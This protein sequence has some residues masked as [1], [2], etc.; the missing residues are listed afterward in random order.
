MSSRNHHQKGRI[1]SWLDSIDPFGRV[2]DTAAIVTIGFAA[3]GLIGI[4]VAW[5]AFGG[6]YVALLEQL[7]QF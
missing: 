5:W 2:Y 7:F 1:E 3:F 4:A 6:Q